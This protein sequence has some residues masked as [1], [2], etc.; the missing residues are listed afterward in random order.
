[1]IEVDGSY[2]EG[3]GQILRTAIGLSILT[4]EAVRIHHIRANRPRP[5]L[6]PQHL[7]GLRAAAEISS[8]YVEGDEVDS[9]EVLFKPREVKGGRY[10][11]DVGTAG[12]VSLILQMLMP[13][14]LR[15]EDTIQLRM[16][17]GTDVRWSPPIDYLTNVT[18]PALSK[19]GLRA[20]IRLVQ[21]GY[22]PQGGGEVEAELY[23]SRLKNV[24]FEADDGP[25]YGISHSRNLPAHI[26]DRQAKTARKLLFEAGYDSHIKKDVGEGSSTGTGTVLW[27]GFIGSSSLGERGKRA[28]VVAREAVMSLI[29][30]LSSGA[31]VDMHL[32]DQLIPYMALVGGEYSV[33]EVT[34]HTSTNIWAAGQI[35]EADFNVEKEDGLFR[36]SAGVRI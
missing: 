2:G 34:F 31:A 21:R 32:A 1:M 4:G 19:M 24:R 8:A 5:G 7:T 33:R 35:V 25:V 27:R 14:A 12:S 10:K 36:I 16:R 18:L 28:E 29:E 22:Y 30:E 26:V 20:D 23:P 9:T 6:A 11:V 17:G 3:G 13:A 15:A